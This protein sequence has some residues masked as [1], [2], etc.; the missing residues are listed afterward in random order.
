MGHIL[1][2]RN[3]VMPKFLWSHNKIMVIL[4]KSHVGA[5]NSI[6]ATMETIENQQYVKISTYK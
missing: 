2:I 6:G 4:K 3:N 5:K 1:Y